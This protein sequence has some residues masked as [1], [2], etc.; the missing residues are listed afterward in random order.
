MKYLLLIYQGDTP[1]YATLVSSA[2]AGAV[3]LSR[4]ETA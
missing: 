4:Y 3:T 2:S 1:I